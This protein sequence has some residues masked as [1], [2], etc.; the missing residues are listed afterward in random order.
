VSPDPAAPRAAAQDTIRA[1]ASTS[2]SATSSVVGGI[3]KR[4]TRRRARAAQVFA[5][6]TKVVGETRRATRRPDAEAR[7]RTVV[8]TVA[9]RG[10]VGVDARMHDDRPT[11]GRTDERERRARV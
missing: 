8:E 10:V 1:I 2:E 4:R 5:R 11:D 7:L 6:E 9:V 3:E